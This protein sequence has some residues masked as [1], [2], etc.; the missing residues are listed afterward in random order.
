MAYKVDSPEV[1]KARIKTL[2]NLVGIKNKSDKRSIAAK[3][4]FMKIDL[5]A[6]NNG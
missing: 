5:E 4:L 1:L 6:A 2:T 3:I